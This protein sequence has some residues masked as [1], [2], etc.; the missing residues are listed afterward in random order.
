VT[1]FVVENACYVAHLYNN[2]N[3]HVALKALIIKSQYDQAIGEEAQN[4]VI[5]EMKTLVS[6]SDDSP[7]VQL[8]AAQLFLAHGLTKDALQLVYSGATLEHVALTLQI[9]L[10]LDRMDLANRQLDK[11]RA[12]DEDAVLT[13]IAA[14]QVALAGGASSASDAAHYLNSLSEQYG[15]SP[16]LLNLS[17]CAY[18][19]IADYDEAETKLLDCKREFPGQ[20]NPETLINL[21]VVTQ[22]LGKPSEEYITELKESFP[23]HPFLAGLER[24]EGAFARESMKYKVAA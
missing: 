18:I 12:M 1:Y 9:F 17:A 23:T 2:M 15:P 13:S 24:V 5:D 21:V 3:I 6:G 10:K 14:V 22:Y 4:V 16:L 8:Y 19:M 20:P 11:L 7:S